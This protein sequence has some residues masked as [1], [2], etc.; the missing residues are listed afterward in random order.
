[1]MGGIYVDRELYSSNTEQLALYR[2][3]LEPLGVSV[4]KWSMNVRGR[5][6]SYNFAD[7]FGY[8]TNVFTRDLRTSLTSR[9]VSGLTDPDNCNQLVIAINNTISGL[10]S[11]NAVPRYTD[12]QRI[13]NKSCMECHG[14]LDYP[15]YQN[16]GTFLDLSENETPPAGEDRL[17]RPYGKATAFVT[18]DPATSFLYQRITATNDDCRHPSSGPPSSLTLMPCGGPP[19]SKV[20]IETIRRWIVGTTPN[21]RGDPHIVTID[22]VPYDFQSAGEFVLLRGQGLEIQARQTAIGTDGP[23]GPNGHTGLTSCVS[24]NSAAAF[25]VGNHRITYQPNTSGEADRSGLQLRIDGKLSRITNEGILLESGG[26]IIQTSVAGGIQIEAPGGTVIAVT[27]RFWD[28]YQVWLLDIDVRNARATEGVMGAMAPG[29]WLPALPDGSS[30]GP[31]PRDLH[32]RYLDLYDK[33][34][35]AWRV[36][37]ATTLFDYAPGTSTS[38]FTVA[39]WPA[40][41]PGVCTAPPRPPSGPL[42]KAPL[43]ALALE[44]AQQHCAAIAGEQ[45]KANCVQDVMVT[46]EPGFAQLY[47][48][49]EQVE[50]NSLPAPP[51]LGFPETF[52]TGL[53]APVTFT[54][55][56]T[57]D[58]NGDPL[59]YKHCVW[60]V[61][62]RFNFDKCVLAAGPTQTSSWWRGGLFH[63]VLVLLLGCLLL[64]ILLWLGLK[65]KPVLLYLLV[66]A[67]LAGVVVA[68]YLG[69]TKS[70]TGSATLAKSV[71]GLQAGKAYYWKVIAEDG[72]GGTVESE[73]RRFEIK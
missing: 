39:N 55:N 64:A 9:P 53:V 5:S 42:A 59:I 38:T 1:V 15:P 16:Y 25:R 70:Q 52:K 30:L 21:T 22:G 65:K 71:S 23:L 54:W 66:I 20:D 69:K 2:Y 49:G 46:G 34:E 45:A 31:R 28:Y 63:A 44:V 19:L 18:A 67:I 48:L 29:S 36:S 51:V 4:D 8:Y 11:A 56:S 33:F 7:V 43:K 58:L 60:E 41:N 14:G 37:D 57:S 47:L 35:T 68:F 6:R 17:D 50:R 61:K 12:V 27:P 26:R 72:K 13:F 3:F 24:V 73:M 10:P 40:E 62:D 32:Q